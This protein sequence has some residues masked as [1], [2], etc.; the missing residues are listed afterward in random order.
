MKIILFALL[1]GLLQTQPAVC[2]NTEF[3]VTSSKTDSS[4]HADSAMLVL[5]ISDSFGYM[6]KPIRI[7]VN[8]SDEQLSAD[9]NGTFKLTIKAQPSQ[10]MLYRSGYLEVI[11]DTIAVQHQSLMHVDVTLKHVEQRPIPI[12]V[13]KPVIYVYSPTDTD[14][15]IQVSA[16]GN[17][18]FT[19]PLLPE[20]GWHL[21]TQTDGRLLVDNKI[22]NYLF[23]ES[24]IT[25][26]AV[27]FNPDQGFL[28]ASDTLLTFLES[29]LEKMGFLPTEVADFITYWYP[30]MIKN[31]INRI[32]FLFNNACEQY[33]TLNIT[34]AP[35]SVFRLGMWWGSAHN[36]LVLM[37]Q[38]LPKI[39][40]QGLTVVEWGGAE[41][42]EKSLKIGL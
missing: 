33:A 3:R 17:M 15:R 24:E 37:P 41:V 25:P 32:H 11:T 31:P 30:A 35:A 38:Q 40:R 5:H 2:Q 39:E 1:L 23:W 10:I 7:G 9:E 27:T 28:V 22:Y 4:I 8:G 26:D 6:T 18:L 12:Q 36:E 29:S 19:Y 13:R 21:R 16:Q 20:N 42:S 14:V 34:P